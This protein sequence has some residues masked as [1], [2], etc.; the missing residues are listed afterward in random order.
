[1]SI[2]EP[3]NITDARKQL[4]KII[5]QARAD[6]EPVYLTKRGHRVAAVIDADDLDGIMALAEDMADIRAAEQ[7]RAEMRVTGETPIPWE[8]VKVDLGLV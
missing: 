6:H 7:A 1:M 2:S 5:D 4:A 8:R 3:F